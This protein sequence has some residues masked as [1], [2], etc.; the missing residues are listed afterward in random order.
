MNS[1]HL[2]PLRPVARPASRRARLTR[3]IL[4]VTAGAAVLALAS[5]TALA[6]PP[7]PAQ[8]DLAA[9]SAASARSAS[10]QVLKLPEGLTQASVARDSFAAVAGVQGLAAGSTNRD[11]AE[12]VL[13][14]GDFPRTDD[15]ITV[16]LRWMRQENGPD[17]WWNRNNPLNNGWGSGGNSGLG[18][19]DN[20]VIAAENAAEALH[21]N[22]G[23]AGIVA[24]FSSSAPTSQIEQAIWAS[25]WATSHYA[26]G[27][28]WSYTPVP[29]IESPAGTW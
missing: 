11:W 19:Y 24:G 2:P 7:A 25:P 1:Y 13:L 6:P 16:M 10:E 22:P 29:V 23:Y 20:L 9:A 12:L 28:H 4:G 17:N 8:D 21:S 27:A 18:S 14:L 5:L 26:N 15:N 3:R